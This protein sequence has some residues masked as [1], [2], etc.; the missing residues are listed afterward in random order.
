VTNNK[1]R[2]QIFQFNEGSTF[3]ENDYDFFSIHEH[4]VKWWN[5]VFIYGV[6]FYAH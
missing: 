4:N 1:V 2:G 6:L 5:N 3:V